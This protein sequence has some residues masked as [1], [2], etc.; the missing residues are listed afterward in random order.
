MYNSAYATAADPDNVEVVALMDIGEGKYFFP[1]PIY[2]R[3][4]RP[5][6]DG[7][8]H[9]SGLWSRAWEAASG[10]V[11]MMCAD[12]VVFE[13]PGWDERVREAFRSVPDRIVMV[14]AHAKMEDRPVLPFVS[15]EWIDAAGFTPDH[16]QGWFSDEWIWS[17]AAEIG[18]VIFLDDVVIS[19]EQVAY[20]I[21][22]TQADGMDAREHMGG[23][24][25]MRNNFYSIPEV[26]K[27]DALTEKLRVVM[28]LDPR[29][30][31][32]A[33]TTQWEQDSLRN[34][35]DARE[36]DRMIQNETLVVV[37][38]YSGDKEL[39]KNAL[40]VHLAHNGHVLILSPTDA[41]VKIRRSGVECRSAGGRGY[42]GQVSLDRQRA[43]LELLLTYPHKYFLLND[44]DS[45]CLTPY[46]PRYLY[47]QS[48]YVWSNEVHEW[49]PHASP[50]PKIAMQ[51]PYFISRENIER[52]LSVADRPEVLAHPITP[53]IDWYMVALCHEAGVTHRNFKDGASFPAWGWN[54]DEVPDTTQMGNDWV[55]LNKRDATVRGDVEMANRVKLGVVMVH[56]V[57]HPEVLKMLLETHADYVRRGS[58]APKTL[59][60]DQYFE[61]RAAEPEGDTIR[62]AI[63]DWSRVGE[64]IIQL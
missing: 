39:V 7:R 30:I 50:Y 9:M 3:A 63:G 16:L 64:D 48:E 12:D 14:Y 33:P 26:R 31:P 29:G 43:H 4:E 62:V 27:R 11:A 35:A 54:R 46:I 22:Q 32:Y 53:F 37:H 49:R 15:R 56:S 10:D 23:L 6:L 44:A 58:P 18:R 34:N 1:G 51:P 21:D 45:M 52:L 41:P 8:T 19:H 40:P 24:D 25:S 17:M 55:W 20:Q 36:H 2:A 47:K 38:A 28:Q 61:Q 5:T 59:T 42:F 13:T 57:K 60:L